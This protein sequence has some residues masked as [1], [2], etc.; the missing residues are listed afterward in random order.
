MD[1]GFEATLEKFV[2]HIKSVHYSILFVIVDRQGKFAFTRIQKCWEK[3]I[4][5]IYSSVI[6]S[7]PQ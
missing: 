6:F 2:I 4:I 1:L 3:N 5:S 7:K